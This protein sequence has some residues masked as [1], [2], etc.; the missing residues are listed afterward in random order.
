MSVAASAGADLHGR[1][2]RSWLERGGVARRDAL[3]GLTAAVVML[4]VEGSYG[5]AALAPLGPEAVRIAFLWGV[6]AAVAAN[7]GGALAGGRGP[8][9]S[10]SGAAVA[11]LVPPLALALL[12]DPRF[13]LADQRPNVPLVL[14]VIAL[15]V[16][17]AGLLQIAIG[18]SRLG[19]IAKFVP[20]PVH[21]GFM[22]GVAVLMVVAM[23]P[24][25][26]GVEARPGVPLALHDVR[27]ASLLVALVTLAVAVRPPRFMRPVPS[28]LGAL[29]VG[30]A[31]HHGLAAAGAGAALGPLLGWL[32]APWPRADALA[33]L[34]RPASFGLLQAHLPSLLQFAVAVALVSS[35]QSLLAASV[36]DGMTQQRRDGDRLLL[37]EG[38][39]NVA[40]GV[41]GAVPSAGGVARSTIGLHAGATTV[42]SRVVFGLGLLLL[43]GF[44]GDALR[45]LPMAVIAAVFVAAALRLV[46][47]WTRRATGA[48]LRQAL[49][50]QRP[51]RSLAQNYAVMLLV[52][53]T[54][55]FASVPLAVALG[56][57]VAMLMFI[58]SNSRRP[59][60]SVAPGRRS[61]KVRPAAATQLLQAHG[62]RIVLIELDGALF[63]GTADSVARQIERLA[64]DAEHVVVD[65]RRVS[66]VDATGARLLLQAA[67]TV[68]RRGVR[69]LV[70][71]LGAADPRA[72]T[73]REM[74]IEA[75]LDDADFHPDADRALEAAE[76]RLLASLG[77]APPAH[78]R[79]A[80]ED[81]M[82]GH[83]LTPDEIE[84]LT[85]RL[86]E[87]PVA[88]G[89]SVFEQGDPGDALYVSVQGEI[90]IR[91][92]DDH[93]GN[94]A[95]GGRRIV[96]FAP[97]VVFGEIAL[98][99]GQCRSAAARAEEDALLLRLS[100]ADYEWL[101]IERPALFGKLLLNLGL[102][103]ATRVRALTDEIEASHR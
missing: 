48:V 71:S 37:A 4:A 47:G 65:F 2:W 62:G 40:C 63:F 77:A 76:D 56:T 52:A 23:L 25:L 38:F 66:D 41:I 13:V 98:L 73:I 92:A 21:A 81:T 7:L 80:L 84:L 55:V 34:L 100:R 85:K 3:G 11:L 6:L 94:G 97:G 74:D 33:P 89:A 22:N 78:A 60:R 67:A 90:G 24:H 44:G 91:L 82:L 39:G 19:R 49:R 43:V 31:L 53:A 35:L 30:V 10:G 103:L 102:Q 86:L 8:L 61:L 68:E 12:A 28:S 59:V 54:S 14:A 20:Y 70:A 99:T 88:R 29:L 46:D 9:L 36:I 72:R 75:V 26:L 93:D 45:H 27:P 69:L 42:A 101:R 51:P 18:A 15:G 83:G 79:L 50:R 58:R 96:S 16:V 1:W 57:F 64:D 87:V 17:L 95:G 5:V 32:E